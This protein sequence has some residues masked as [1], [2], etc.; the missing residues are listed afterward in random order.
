MT[1]PHNARKHARLGMSSAA[2]WRKCP[3]S[4]ALIDT[5]PPRKPTPAM[6]EG[7]YAHEWCEHILQEHAY[8]SVTATDFIGKT[9]S[10][11]VGEP[12][13][14]KETADAI[15]VYLGAVR[16]VLTDA[17]ELLVEHTFD[18]SEVDRDC[19]GTNDAIVYDP[20]F[21]TLHVFDYKHG[22]G[23]FVEVE[24]NDQVLG[25]AYGGWIKYR[26]RGVSDIV[27]TIVQPRA[28]GESVRSVNISVTD[29]VDW[30]L[31][32]GAD[33]ARTRDPKAACV[34]GPHCGKTFCPARA[35]ACK[36]FRAEAEA[37]ATDG[38][39]DV[40]EPAAVTRMDAKTLG[41]QL[42][43]AVAL[44]S[45]L[46]ALDEF[47]KQE[48]DAGRVPSGFKMV[49][50]R[51][52]REW[53]EDLPSGEIAGYILK[54]S[55]EVDPYERKLISPAQA[56]KALG[57]RTFAGLSELVN[58]KRGLI[59]VDISDPRPPAEKQDATGFEPINV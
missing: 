51:G 42:R 13:L 14:T 11:R 24:G 59:M 18:L 23:S 8:D 34:V 7:T 22:A 29:L 40:I 55:N 21:E 9:L 41:D 35:T 49:E 3:A 20:V 44:R 38:F 25:Y 12:E 27:V 58:V 16:D 10:G 52:R 1:A 54:V 57:K 48:C 28:G 53:R 39:G 2:R 47:A 5:L 15:N 32:A 43:K 26:D 37:A 30:G 45:Y 6:L 33:A 19:G 36:A 56:E 17:A 31:D 46:A 50:G 4:V